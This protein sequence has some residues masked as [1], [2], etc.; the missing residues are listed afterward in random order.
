MLF[1]TLADLY[2]WISSDITSSTNQFYYVE[3]KLINIINYIW[4]LVPTL[5]LKTSYQFH[6]VTAIRN[7]ISRR[8]LPTFFI[9]PGFNSR[10]EIL[11]LGSEFRI[12]CHCH[13]ILEQYILRKHSFVLTANLKNFK[14][15]I[16]LQCWQERCVFLILD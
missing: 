10:N 8:K 1:K 11:I 12:I 5:T 15:S 6:F 7:K 2:K 9:F 13:I 3:K 4:S 14:T 16:Q